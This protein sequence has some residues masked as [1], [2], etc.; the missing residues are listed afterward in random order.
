MALP[1]ISAT[2]NLTKDPDLGFTPT[3][4]AR[5][6]LAIACNE[7]KN[8]DGK[9]VDGDTTYLDVVAWRE[10]AENAVETL[11]KGDAVTVIGKLRTRQYE[12]DGE[13]RK[14]TEVDA[15]SIA[16]DLRKHSATV[17]R[18]TRGEPRDAVSSD[19]WTSPGAHDRVDDIPPF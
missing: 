17:N 16:F 13:T 4:V 9:W 11:R 15:E 19:P 5:A 18:I 14:V 7:R 12:K 8:Q 3:G 1:R 6:N 2:G 10:V